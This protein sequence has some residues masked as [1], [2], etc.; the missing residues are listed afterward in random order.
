MSNVLRALRAFGRLAV[1]APAPP[2]ATGGYGLA[3]RGALIL[4]FLLGLALSLW[5]PGAGLVIMIVAALALL[6]FFLL[7]YQ[8]DL[9]RRSV[10]LWLAIVAALGGT[11]VAAVWSSWNGRTGVGGDVMVLTAF[12]LALGVLP[13]VRVLFRE[14]FGPHHPE[15]PIPDRAD[16]LPLWFWI[17]G[18]GPDRAII[19]VRV[20]STVNPQAVT[21]HHVHHEGDPTST[22]SETVDLDEHRLATVTL[23]GLTADQRY[24]LRIEAVSA[25]GETVTGMAHGAFTTFPVER[26]PASFGLAFAS[27]TAT[28]SRGR[29]FDTIG[30]VEPRPR[31]FVITGDMHYEN[32]T[33]KRTE[34]FLDAFDMVHRSGAQRRLYNSMPMAY[35]WDDHDY[36]DNDSD[37]RSPSRAAAR[38]AYRLAVPSYLDPD[39]HGPINQE[40]T[41]GRV[42]VLMTDN[43]SERA[44]TPGHLFGQKQERWLI[45]RINDCSWPLVIWVSSTPWISSDAGS[46]NWGAYGEQRRRIANGIG[47]RNAN[48]LMVSGDAHMV[49]IDDGSNSA[50]GGP[51]S[52]FPVLHA[53][54]L[55]RRGSTKGGPFSHGTFPGSGQFGIV[56]IDDLGHEIDVHLSGRTWTGTEI[57]GH[58]FTVALEPDEAQRSQKQT[59]NERGH[60]P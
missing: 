19:R 42:L 40:F 18:V 53:A 47:E 59:I 49:A 32:L 26:A 45:E 3:C 37:A 28:G 20:A 51:G 38:S 1:G 57:I 36:G 4:L 52:G 30:E 9:L 41:I 55:D 50:Y 12:V 56:T 43:R 8:E 24:D 60:D 39:Q 11:A 44:E 17:G 35:V 23:T 15:S 13:L 2:R 34:S 27:C 5:S 58:S 7:Q 31:V 29:V 14:I 10:M 22:R 6:Q 21:V 33:S 48:L 54:A 16:A 46:D 25:N